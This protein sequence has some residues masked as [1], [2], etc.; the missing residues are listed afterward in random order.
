MTLTYELNLDILKMYQ[1]CTFYAKAFTIIALQTHRQT[2]RQ[3][4]RCDRTHYHAT[5]VGVK[6][7]TITYVG[8][9]SY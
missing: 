1:K 9:T 3:T 8:P 2:D 6:L 5:F 7:L 4:D